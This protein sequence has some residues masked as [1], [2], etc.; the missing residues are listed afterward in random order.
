MREYPTAKFVLTIR[1][2]E[3]WYASYTTH[4]AE[5]VAYYGGVLPF[6]LTALLT[7]VYGSAQND[8]ATWLDHYHRHNERVQS[9]I[10]PSQLLVL[11]VSEPDAAVRLCAFIGDMSALCGPSARFPHSNSKTDREERVTH[12]LFD[13]RD[14]EVPGQTSRVAYV[15]VYTGGADV[16]A[17]ERLRVSLTSLQVVGVA[18][19]V[20][21]VVVGS[22]PTKLL[23]GLA[24][25]STKVV[26]IKSAHSK[27]KA[28]DADDDYCYLALGLTSY[29]RA[30]VF[31]S[32]LQFVHSADDLMLTDRVFV[33]MTALDLPLDTSAFIT[34]PSWQSMIDVYDLISKRTALF[35]DARGWMDVG[36]GSWRFPGA[37]TMPGLLYYYYFLLHS[38]D[39]AKLHARDTWGQYIILI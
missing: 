19:D 30:L 7:Y 21:V 26:R 2:T 33:G 39:G 32:G 4:H 14:F 8:R 6:R 10:P 28:V 35:S 34:Q 20:V 36:E 24:A 16:T 17:M 25:L 15:T 29:D 3:S 37:S 1:E 5:T 9:I 23:T 38:G 31:R 18:V 13:R 22:I 12:A 11:D 27:S